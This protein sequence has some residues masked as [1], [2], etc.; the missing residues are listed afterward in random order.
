MRKT[1]LA[2]AALLALPLALA[3]EV[4]ITN[5]SGWYVDATTVM[6][7]GVL[8]ATYIVNILTSIGK[9]AWLTTGSRT[10]VLSGVISVIV[11][12]VGGY[13]SLGFLADL[14]GGLDAAL[15]AAGMTIF[16]FIG[17]NLKYNYDK[18][19]AESG[20][21]AAAAKAKLLQ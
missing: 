8:I 5:P 21:K 12:G 17:A 3:A 14:G 18:Q 11:A 10:V 20:A 15:R 4:V 19:V 2:I 7:A 13:L 16:S 1:L 9:G 6:A